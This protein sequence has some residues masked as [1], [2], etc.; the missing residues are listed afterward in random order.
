[1]K[2]W[3]ISP[4]FGCFQIRILPQLGAHKLLQSLAATVKAGPVVESQVFFW[5]KVD[6][7]DIGKTPSVFTGSAVKAPITKDNLSLL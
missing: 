3:V 1:M 4:S 5:V 7:V 6:L 2:S